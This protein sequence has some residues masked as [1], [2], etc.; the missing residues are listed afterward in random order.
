MGDAPNKADIRVAD[1]VCLQGFALHQRGNLDAAAALYR[2]ALQFQPAHFDATHLL[3]LV[4]LNRNRTEMAATLFEKAIAINP[5]SY[6]AHLNYGIALAQ[7]SRHGAALSSFKQALLLQPQAAEAY[8]N[9]ANTL[10]QM[11]RPEEA[12]LDYDRAIAL[13]CGFVDAL[14]NRARLSAN[15]GRYQAAIADSDAILAL[16][17]DHFGALI[18]RSAA[19]I[20]LQQHGAALQDLQRAHE[21]R[22]RSAQVFRRIGHVLLQQRRYDAAIKALDRALHA[23]EQDADAHEFEARL[24]RASSLTGL[25]RHEE[26]S[27]AYAILLAEAPH[28]PY[29]SGTAFHSRLNICDW[30]G[31]HEIVERLQERVQRDELVDHPFS[32]LAVTDSVAMQARCVRNFAAAQFGTLQG[33]RW[34]PRDRR[35]DGRLRIAYLSAD[36]HEHATSQLAAGLFEAHD[37]TNFEVTAVSYGPDDGSPM[38]ARIKS[39]FEHFL[40]V[41]GESDS[42]IAHR[43]LAG[44][45]DIAIDLKGHTR[46]SRPG[47][48]ASRPAALQVSYLGFPGGLSLE[49]IDYLIVDP[50]VIPET[51]TTHYPE[52]QLRLP[53]SY[54]ANDARRPSPAEAPSRSFVG[55]PAEGFVFACF[56]AQYKLNPGIF[57]VW[58]RLLAAVHG[59]VLW[60]LASGIGVRER[61]RREATIRGIAPDRLVFAPRCDHVSHLARHRCADLFLDTFP[62]NA[63]TTASDAL[64]M[65]LPVLTLAGEAFA[66]RVAASLLV[67]MDVPELITTSIAEYEARGYALATQPRLLQAFRDRIAEARRSSSV[68]DS[69]RFCRNFERALQ[70]IWER[71]TRREAPASVN[72]AQH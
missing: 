72:L 58:M 39:A 24:D 54:Q 18:N 53:V 48:L 46:D 10:G 56:N 12:I 6:S 36:F 21:L 35:R 71:H 64:W 51:L 33:V 50:V 13:N 47:I 42:A 57:S 41:S 31:Y 70:T 60:L 15:L 68:F 1:S 4:A 2:K 7:L 27:E 25:S 16:Q 44:D 52:A 63:H 22:P 61:L 28:Y 59:S 29:M 67:A 69:T 40:E 32:F 45:I 34:R 19:H 38:R 3:G 11:G 20:A 65:G 49:W 17:P 62:V 55:L 9:R 30:E 8:F 23:D 66:S 43:L 5:G 14:H 26:A 37:R